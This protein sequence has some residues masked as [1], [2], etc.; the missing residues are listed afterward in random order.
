MLLLQ[1]DRNQYPHKHDNTV[2]EMYVMN[3]NHR[4]ATVFNL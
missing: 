2:I 3:V 1:Y 4:D